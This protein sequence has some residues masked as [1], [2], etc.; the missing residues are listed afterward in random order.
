MYAYDAAS[1]ARSDWLLSCAAPR[2]ASLDAGGI[3]WGRK[4]DERWHNESFMRAIPSARQPSLRN[5]CNPRTGGFPGIARDG[6]EVPT[7]RDALW[8]EVS[9]AT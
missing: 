4:E 6:R 9:R 2:P 5:M 7:R 8:R 3:P 1:D